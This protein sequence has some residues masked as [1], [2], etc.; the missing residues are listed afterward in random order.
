MN[1]ELGSEGERKVNLT[2]RPELPCLNQM[3]KF[4]STIKSLLVVSQYKQLMYYNCY[5]LQTE[6]SNISVRGRQRERER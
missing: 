2:R 4:G 1:N 5:S 3:Y 6:Y